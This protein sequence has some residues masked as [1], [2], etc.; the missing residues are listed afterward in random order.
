MLP[1]VVDVDSSHGLVDWLRGLQAGQAEMREHQYIPLAQVRAWAGLPWRTPL[2]DSYL[3]F[4][5]FPMDSAAGSRM[6]E[7]EPGIGVTQT[8]HPLRVLFWPVDGLAVEVS[9]YV[10]DFEPATVRRLLDD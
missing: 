5:N 4:E 6:A 8:E 3:V 7:W 10:A 9:Y 1:A 2:Y